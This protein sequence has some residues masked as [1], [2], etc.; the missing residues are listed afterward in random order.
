M[1]DAL[2]T[3]LSSYF[4]SLV[5]NLMN[6][7]R[8]PLTRLTRQ[9]DVLTVQRGVYLDLRS[10]LDD[11]KERVQALLSSSPFFALESGRSIA[12]TDPSVSGAMVLSA[13]V[14]NTA[15]VGEY[16]V[17]VN[18]LARAEQWVSAEQS[19]TDR[20]LGKRGVFYLGGMGTAVASL[21]VSSPSVSAVS[22]GTVDSGLRELGSGDQ[23]EG[24]AYMLEVRQSEAGYEFRLRAADGLP[25]AI[26]DKAK[27]DGTL[28]E[29]WQA[30]T[31]GETYDTHRGL[32]IVFGEA[33]QVGT[34]AIDYQAAG[35]AVHVVESD[36]LANVV[37]K[38]NA[39][40][41]PEG[42]DLIASMVG[43]H[44]VLTAR[45]TGTAHR[46]VVQYVAEAGGDWGSTLPPETGAWEAQDAQ[47]TVNGIS[48][49]RARNTN[50][51]DVLG[52]VSLN[53]AFDAAG[54]SATL[55]IETDYSRARS[56]VDAFAQKFNEVMRYLEEKTAITKQGD[57]YIRGALANDTV[58]SELRYKLLSLVMQRHE[59]LGVY[60]SLS[61]VGVSLDSNLR[62]SLASPSR[63]EAAMRQNPQAVV[64]VFDAVM[65]SIYTELER[66]NGGSGYL[67]QSLGVLDRQIGDLGSDINR[68]QVYLADRE[69]MLTEQ[70][71]QIQAQLI[72]LTYAQQTWASIY[73]SV[74][75]LF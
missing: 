34:V 18:Q 31:P 29:D 33:P 61:E 47:F 46:M 8:Q 11:L 20:P 13:T 12:V 41:Q 75:R 28:T 54:K 48:F 1:V 66:F 6:L 59:T 53:L 52:G 30:L 32:V 5:S 71:A 22:V 21:P 64:Q 16:R 63:F 25:V 68:F 50:L 70:Y 42:R 40:L 14:N 73:G 67:P 57:T 23:A 62:L 49:T 9:R 24:T 55:K 69:A 10:Q 45:Q 37:T 38:L 27:A 60:K 65:G 15:M 74:N 17:Q 19:S 44:L 39:A 36:S 51:T 7:E 3:T 58:F 4:T 43:A 35:V 2:N 72:S 56:A 26:Y